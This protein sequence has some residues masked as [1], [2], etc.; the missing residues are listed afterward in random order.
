MSQERGE[1]RRQVKKGI[2]RH[3]N[4]EVISQGNNRIMRREKDG[5]RRYGNDKADAGFPPSRE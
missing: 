3:G 1:A 5:V 2:I 4:D